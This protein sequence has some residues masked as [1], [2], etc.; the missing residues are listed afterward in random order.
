MDPTS[1]R[2]GLR[3]RAFYIEW[4]EEGIEPTAYVQFSTLLQR[5]SKPSLIEF[6]ELLPI[7]WRQGFSRRHT[8]AHAMTSRRS[9]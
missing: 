9:Q 6:D 1:R 8:V 7:D 4:A 3:H 2:E 5:R